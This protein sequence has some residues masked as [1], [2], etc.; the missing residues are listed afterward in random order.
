MSYHVRVRV[1]V[2]DEATAA[3]QPAWHLQPISTLLEQ[4]KEGLLPWSSSCADPAAKLDPRLYHI[5]RQMGMV[6]LDLRAAIEEKSLLHY[7][8][9]A[10]CQ[11]LQQEIGGLDMA[12]NQ[13]QQ[14]YEVQLQ[15]V[16]RLEASLEQQRVHSAAQQYSL[17]VALAQNEES[18]RVCQ[19]RKLLRQQQRSKVARLLL[20]AENLFSAYKRSSSNTAA[21]A[22]R[23]AAAVAAGLAAERQGDEADSDEYEDDEDDDVDITAAHEDLQRPVSPGMTAGS[24]AAA[25]VDQ[26]ASSPYTSSHSAAAATAALARCPPALRASGVVTHDDMRHQPFAGPDGVLT[27][28]CPANAWSTKVG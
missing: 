15:E 24:G 27:G 22:L 21:V 20:K 26:A 5:K 3:A 6:A 19:A 13:L 28:P 4:L 11:G 14:Q 18:S 12:I 7:E 25:G 10:F 1:Q 8:M 17:C 23:A 16:S 2:L 9:T